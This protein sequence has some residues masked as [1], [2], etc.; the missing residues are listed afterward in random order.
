MAPSRGKQTGSPTDIR[1]EVAAGHYG[2]ETVVVSGQNDDIDVGITEDI[3]DGGGVWVPPTV[4]RNHDVVS[5]SVS[6]IDGGTGMQR[7]LVLGLDENYIRHSEMVVMNGTTSVATLKLFTMINRLVHVSVGSGAVNIGT[8]TATAQ[9]DGTVT[10]QMNPGIN[11]TRMGI[12]AIPGDKVG[13][14]TKTRFVFH[15]DVIA[16]PSFI[17][18]Q[19]VLKSPFSDP[20]KGFISS[21]TTTLNNSS[22]HTSDIDLSPY[23]KLPART[24]LKAQALNGSAANNKVT[25]GFQLILE[26]VS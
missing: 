2:L 23:R 15:R 24:L 17:D 22:G 12:Y 7:V 25:G 10:A 5:T 1:F 13:Y 9:T 11:Q 8:I 26:G 14:M 19:I 3:W 6:D 16:P 20:S 18:T 4:A 21:I